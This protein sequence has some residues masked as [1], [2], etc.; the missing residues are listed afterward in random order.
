MNTTIGR[1]KYDSFPSAKI[2]IIRETTKFGAS[3][4]IGISLKIP[5]CRYG[6]FSV[7]CQQWCLME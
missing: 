7:L 2:V 1:V 3:S 4:K 5:K 6:I